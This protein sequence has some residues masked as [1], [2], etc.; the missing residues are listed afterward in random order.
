VH[1]AGDVIIL[2]QKDLNPIEPKRSPKSCP[3]CGT[4]LESDAAFCP[5]CGNKVKG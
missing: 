5:N 3:S 4:K 2:R 1:A